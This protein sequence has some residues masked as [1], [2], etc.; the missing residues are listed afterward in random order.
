MTLLTGT[1]SRDDVWFA[2]LRNKGT[3]ITARLKVGEF[4]RISDIDAE[5]ADI[6]NRFVT[7][8]DDAGLWKL[9]LGQI[10]RDRQL[11]EPAPKPETEPAAAAI[12]SDSDSNPATTTQPE[13]AAKPMPAAPAPATP[14][15]PTPAAPPATATVPSEPPPQTPAP[16]PGQTGQPAP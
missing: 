7:F 4:I 10:L 3:G 15:E 5:I 1:V 12:P 16:D 2:W 8:R 11:I 14:T 6:T 9:E 13:P